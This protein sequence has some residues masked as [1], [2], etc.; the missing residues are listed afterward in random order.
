MYVGVATFELHIP[1]SGSLKE[2]RSVVRAL[3]DRMR[4]RLEISVAEVALNDLHQRARLA[5][6]MVSGD[7]AVIERAFASVLELVENEADAELIG[8]EQELIPFDD[9]APLPLPR[10]GEDD[11]ELT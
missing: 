11:T 9:G 8:W 2:K 5:L 4:A 6:A 10:F 3:R 7:A 1:F